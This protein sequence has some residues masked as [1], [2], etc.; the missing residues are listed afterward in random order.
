[1]LF[2]GHAEADIRRRLIRRGLIAGI[3]GLP[4]N[5]FY[6]TGIPACILVIDK[7]GAAARDAIFMID[8]SHGF[9]K[10][11]NKNRLRARDIHKIVDTYRRRQDVPGYARLVPVAEITNE[12]NDG[13]LNIPRYIASQDSEDQ[14]DLYA[15]LNPCGIPAADIDALADYWQVLPGVRDTLFSPLPTGEGLGV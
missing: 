7:A 13:N 1:V 12:A 4:A 3:I 6:G 9:I 5:L 8:A 14:Q 2:R 15:H 10:D 11:G